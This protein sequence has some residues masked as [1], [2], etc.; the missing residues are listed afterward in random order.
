MNTLHLCHWQN[1]KHFKNHLKLVGKL[2]SVV[3]YGFVCS[4][5]KTWIAENMGCLGH[6]WY[7]V[8]NRPN[9]NI[10]GHEISYQQW[11]TLIIKYKNTLTWK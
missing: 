2:D 11:L 5:D 3:I 4:D 10:N 7:L 1:Q 6:K 8:N 9:P